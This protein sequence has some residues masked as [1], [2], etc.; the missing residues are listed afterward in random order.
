MCQCAAY[1]FLNAVLYWNTVMTHG[2]LLDTFPRSPT[3]EKPAKIVEEGCRCRFLD[4]QLSSIIVHDFTRHVYV[5]VAPWPV[6][7]NLEIFVIDQPMQSIR[8]V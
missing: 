4:I 2:S 7:N 8:L 6:Q 1:S 5:L 3:S